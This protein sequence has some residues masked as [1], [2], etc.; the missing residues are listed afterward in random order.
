M[1]SSLKVHEP[2]TLIEKIKTEI[3]KRADARPSGR[4]LRGLKRLAKRYG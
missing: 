3:K 4:S 2:N 1:T